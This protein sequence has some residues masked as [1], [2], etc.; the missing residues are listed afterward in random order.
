MNNPNTISRV[1]AR[2]I[3]NF[4]GD[5]TIEAEVLLSDGS[6]GREAAPA[7]VS[8][9]SNEVGQLLDGDPTRFAG[10]GVLKAVRN[11][12]EIIGPALEGMRASQ[13]EMIDRKLL[14]LDG[15]PN[16]SRLGGNAILAV[17]LATAQAAAASQKL[18]LYKYLGA[19]GPF[20]LPVPVFDIFYGG[21]HAEGSVDFQE[22]LVIPAGVPNYREALEAG[23]AIFHKLMELL[24]K[25]GVSVDPMGSLAAPLHSNQEGVELVASAIEKAGFK[26]GGQCFIGIDAATSELYRDGK[27]VLRCEGRELTSSELADL[28]SEWVDT[29]PIISIED[30]MSEEDWSGWQALTQRIGS[31][32]QLVGDDFFTTNPERVKK[33]ITLGAANAV[34]IKPNQIGTLSET[35]ETIR[36][37]NQAGWATMVSTRSGGT[38]NTTIADLSVLNGCGQI[39]TGPPYGKNVIKHNRLLRIEEELGVEAEYKGVQA[40]KNLPLKRARWS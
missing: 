33:G 29:Y 11:V 21:S 17:S 25:K 7:G 18:P 4:S 12:R 3:L 39:K 5:P 28:W 40:F 30:A 26:L 8:V 10:K 20:A 34:L 6:C 27:Y 24:Q 1:W 16:K 9:G 38:E 23:V 2:E 36:I 32:V 37:A 31:R 13:Q 14:E 35:L 15:T 19:E 22:Y